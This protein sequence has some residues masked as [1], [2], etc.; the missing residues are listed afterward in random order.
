[1]SDF[2]LHQLM[3]KFMTYHQKR[4]KVC[5]YCYSVFSCSLSLAYLEIQLFKSW[6]WVVGQHIG[7]EFNVVVDML[8]N[9]RWSKKYSVNQTANTLMKFSFIP[10]SNAIIQNTLIGKFLLTAFGSSVSLETVTWFV[11]WGP[12][13][14]SWVS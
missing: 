5:L 6:L 4:K 8:I 11:G 10:Y 1:M 3:K 14:D 13:H 7:G 2:R 9:S 12:L